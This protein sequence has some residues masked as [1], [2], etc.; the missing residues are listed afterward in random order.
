MTVSGYSRSSET[1]KS[2]LGIRWGLWCALGFA[3]LSSVMFFYGRSLWVPVYY[4]LAGR[5][6][7]EEAIASYAPQAEPRVMKPFVEAALVYP[8]KSLMLLAFKEERL[9]EVWARNDAR[10]VRIR[11]YPIKGASGGAGPKL[12]QGDGQVPEGVYAIEGLNPNS[13]FHLS[14]KLNYPNVS[15]LLRANTDGRASLGGDI[16]IHGSTGSIGCLA[17]GDEAIEELF[18]L[19]HRVGKENVTVMIAPR[20]LRRLPPPSLNEPK[21]LP[22]VYADLRMRLRDFTKN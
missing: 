22:D 15:D 18:V 6:T 19:V 3:V 11:S 13:S 2:F 4:R 10:W 7:V 16:F 1:R 9:L 17:M 12:R 21:W 20:D 14:M 5:R 8:P